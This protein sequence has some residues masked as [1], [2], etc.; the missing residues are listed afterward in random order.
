MTDKMI[1]ALAEKYHN[2]ADLG[3]ELRKI[4][5]KLKKYEADRKAYSRLL[6]SAQDA[7]NF[8]YQMADVVKP[9]TDVSIINEGDRI[10]FDKRQSYTMMINGEQYT[11][12]QERDVVVVL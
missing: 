10:Y 9:G 1:I 5:I 3:R 6:L 4:A 7:N 12:I 2:D 11:V 8:R